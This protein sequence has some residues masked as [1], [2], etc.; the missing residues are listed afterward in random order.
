MPDRSLA[1]VPGPLL[2]AFWTL[3]GWG[4]LTR[5]EC[6]SLVTWSLYP[7][8]K[9]EL[10]VPKR[11][12]HQLHRPS[13]WHLNEIPGQGEEGRK[14]ACDSVGLAAAREGTGKALSAKALKEDREIALRCSIC[15]CK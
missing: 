15:Q 4:F 5:G 2:G 1:L 13:A 12:C 14:Q 10:F 7:I 11:C 9:L 6:S 8:S 3:G